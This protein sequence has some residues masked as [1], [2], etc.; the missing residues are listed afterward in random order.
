[1]VRAFFYFLLA[2]EFSLFPVYTS[3]HQG[4]FMPSILLNLAFLLFILSS[5]NLMADPSCSRAA[6]SLPDKTRSA[7][8][9]DVANPIEHI[10]VIMQ[11]NHS[12][13]NYFGQL[14][15]PE[16]YGNEIDGVLPNMSNPDRQ[17][18]SIFTYPIPV[19]CTPDPE[20]S[21]EAMHSDWNH[22]ANDGFVRVNDPRIMGYF[23]PQD[24]PFYYALANQFAVAD[25]YFSSALAPTF[26][27]RFFLMTGT[28]FGNTENNFPRG[29]GQYSQKTI[30]DVLNQ[31]GVSWKYYTDDKGYLALFSKLYSSSHSKMLK[32]AD[33]GK[34]LNSK[35]LPKVIFIDANFE[36]E[37][38]HPE[39]DIQLGQ[40]FVATRIHE[41]IASSYW[42]NSVL[43]LTY[44]E[45]GGFY[46]HVNPP[47]AC[48]P[49]QILP[50]PN[51]GSERFDHYGFRV[52]FV[53]VSPYAQH[54]FVSHV[55]HDHTS[56][57]KFIET[58][59][60]LPALTQRD[61]NADNLKDMFDFAHPVLS[62]D[63]PSG[64]MD[65]DR[66]CNVN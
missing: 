64:E 54:H 2:L 32:I 30:F 18:R 20:H 62:T 59:F 19:L 8:T 23:G 17:G 50:Q 57:L 25:R 65:Q 56:I 21:W 14:N 38:E 51:H 35:N 39:A 41:L 27:N 34:D 16:F 12:F 6:G 63:L 11:E 29:P 58:K 40:L 47:V 53:V 15:R 43:F 1:M 4:V 24:L 48:E 3:A 13:D 28:A 5:P 10:I 22:G 36:G 60:N 61:A 7:G 55:V 31:Y 9:A 46:D 66:R 49:D 45:S 26:P 37:D 42:K 44:D 52:P 33:F